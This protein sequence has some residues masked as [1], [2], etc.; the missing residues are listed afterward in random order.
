ME[1]AAAELEKNRE[2][3]G[4]SWRNLAQ[5][6]NFWGEEVDTTITEDGYTKLDGSSLMLK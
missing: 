1:Q 5:G 3:L 2:N 4:N 6:K